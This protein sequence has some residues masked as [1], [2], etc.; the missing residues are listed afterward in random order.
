MREQKIL[1]S[2]MS[3]RNPTHHC[4][5]L[6]PDQVTASLHDWYSYDVG[7]QLLAAI[8]Q[9][10][11]GILPNLFGFN[12]L[13]VGNPASDIDLMA[14]SHIQH[15][16]C[17]DLRATNVALAGSSEAMPFDE[18]SLD[19]VLLMHT[20]EFANDPHQVLR[21]IDRA[22]I[23]EGHLVIVGFNPASLYGLRKLS[24]SRKKLVPWCGHFY[25]VNRLKD[26]LSLLGFKVVGCEYCGFLPPIQRPGIQRRLAFMEPLM[27]RALPFAGG[28]FVLLAQ[29]KVARVTPI[30]T[31]WVPKPRLIT[32]KIPEPTARSRHDE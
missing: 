22:L 21:E 31:S 13:Q 8:S 30:K 11:G 5:D 20:L 17:M 10:L 24:W 26:W 2:L 7:K 28:I 32:G 4:T 18:D 19:L 16:F 29:N 12:A 6:T 27:S 23:P 9:V 25:T 15:R 14:A 1:E 3:S